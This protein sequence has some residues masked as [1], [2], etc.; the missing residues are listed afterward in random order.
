MRLEAKAS[1]R[2]QIY[3]RSSSS[4]WANL[5]ANG[6]A[7][8]SIAAPVLSDTSTRWSS[9]FPPN[10]QQATLLAAAMWVNIRRMF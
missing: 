7:T 5:V 6:G 3:L 8:R 9:G 2:V 4:T 1:K 10:S